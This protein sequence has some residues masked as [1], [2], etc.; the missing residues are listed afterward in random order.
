MSPLPMEK[1][2]VIEIVDKSL[3]AW[4][5]NGVPMADRYRPAVDSMAVIR[6]LDIH[7]DKQLWLLY[8]AA[9]G[10]M[11]ELRAE[12]AELSSS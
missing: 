10:F 7:P 3:K 11:E 8:Y 1:R 4:D 6:S 5:A 12:Y 9:E 2:L